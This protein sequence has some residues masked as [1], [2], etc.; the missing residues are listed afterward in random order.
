MNCLISVIVPVYK[1]EKYLKQCLDSIINQSYKNLEIILVDDGSPDNCGQICDSYAIKDSRIIVI[2]K[3]NCGLAEARNSALDIITGDYVLFID[4]DD[5]LSCDSLIESAADTILRKSGDICLIPIFKF[6]E[7]KNI[8]IKRKNYEKLSLTSSSKYK[9]FSLLLN[10]NYYKVAAWDKI[11]KASVITENNLRFPCG[12]INEDALW[13]ADLILHSK[14]VS[15][16]NTNQMGYVYRQRENSITSNIND[17]C[18]Q[19]SFYNINFILNKLDSLDDQDA[20]DLIKALYA[21]ELLSL[22]GSIDSHMLTKYK[23]YF[24]DHISLFK[25]G[26]NK[27]VN[28]AYYLCRIFGL[29]AA[30]FMLKSAR[31]LKTSLNKSCHE[32]CL[33]FN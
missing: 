23:K 2:H 25:Y 32:D 7:N 22:L 18:I 5:W 30:S 3:Q 27:T 17:K 12:V 9:N 26:K 29:N 10:Q 19:D 28:T 14:S 13:C 31:F 6:Y 4:S 15:V 21:Y 33:N 16:L 24:C 8:F 20:K 11:V 1:V